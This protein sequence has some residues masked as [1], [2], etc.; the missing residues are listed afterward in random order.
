MITF[1]I[2]VKLILKA[3]GYT[4]T[5]LIGALICAMILWIV[6]G[7]PDLGTYTFWGSI[8]LGILGVLTDESAKRE[9]LLTPHTHERSAALSPSSSPVQT[10]R[11]PEKHQVVTCTVVDLTCGVFDLHVTRYTGVEDPRYVPSQEPGPMHLYS[12]R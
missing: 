4:I 8:F 6:T 1:T 10:L 7:N 3:A 9:A 5:I 11:A 2:R 12:G